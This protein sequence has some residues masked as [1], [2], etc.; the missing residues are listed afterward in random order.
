M[1]FDLS[2]I[3]PSTTSP[4]LEMALSIVHS[5]FI[6]TDN[7]ELLVF[8]YL[9]CDW[10]PVYFR[11]FDLFLSLVFD[12]CVDEQISMPANCYC[13]CCARKTLCIYANK[14][15]FVYFAHFHVHYTNHRPHSNKN[16]NEVTI[17]MT[18]IT[19]SEWSSPGEVVG[20]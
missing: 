12:F 6:R 20:G 17:E 5:Y 7:D 2:F 8:N 18:G 11:I 4:N 13:M 10:W 14:C 19:N 16:L 1:N 15:V 9:W 3:V